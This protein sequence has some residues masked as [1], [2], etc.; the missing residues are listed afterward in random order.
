MSIR[1]VLAA[2]LAAFVLALP[3]AA[4]AGPPKGPMWATVTADYSITGRS[5][6]VIT[7]RLP[8]IGGRP[9]GT[10]E[11]YFGGVDITRCA[12]SATT[13]DGWAGVTGVAMGTRDE[14]TV[15]V[16]TLSA[17]TAQLVDLPFHLIVMCPKK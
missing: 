14:S 9:T 5:H 17:L 15:T 12:A 6:S 10:F 3:P 13:S 4:E 16:Y 7:T 2:V 11:I 8:S 1:I